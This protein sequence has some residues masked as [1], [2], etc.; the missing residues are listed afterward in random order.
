MAESA[1]GLERKHSNSGSHVKEDSEYVRLVINNEPAVSE[2]TFTLQSPLE[3]R[4]RALK[5]WVNAFMW[6]IICIVVL[7]VFIKWGV[8]FLFEKVLV[9]I[10]EWEATSFGRPAL[11]L[12]LVASLALFPVL[13]IP[14]APS[15]WLAGMIF[16]YGL[17]FVLIMIGTTVGMLLP[18]LIGLIFRDRIHQWLKKWPQ[19]ADIIRLAGE[20]SSFHQFQVVAL[21]RISPF[22]YTIFN[23][24]VVVTSM[25]FWP[26]L[27][28]SIAG[29]IPEAF[30]YIYSGRLIRTFADV[31]YGNHH[32]TLVEI[33]ANIIS[34]IVAIITTS[35]FTVY[36]KRKLNEQ[37]RTGGS[38]G[39][40]TTGPGKFE[41]ERLPPEKPKQRN[42]SSLL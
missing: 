37:A 21:F 31:Q 27:W 39:C 22:P 20:G 9:P 15:M 24:A 35:A 25:R 7:L 36:A 5:W 13:L 40:S 33:I 6:C 12:I 19:Q 30:L 42:I 41:M 4:Q 32:L 17:G 1:V 10:L 16:G 26:Y 34:F 18:Y 23:Y 2:T 3:T 8:P 28:G 14:S 38:Q 11:A 29:M